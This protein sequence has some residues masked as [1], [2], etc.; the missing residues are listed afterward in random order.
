M[1][2]PW[3]R[4]RSPLTESIRARGTLAKG[5]EKQLARGCHARECPFPAGVPRADLLRRGGRCAW[6]RQSWSRPA[7]LRCLAASS[8]I[9][10][11]RVV[12]LPRA[13]SRISRSRIPHVSAARG[14]AFHRSAARSEAHRRRR[15]LC[16]GPP[17]MA[18][19]LSAQLLFAAGGEMPPPLNAFRSWAGKQQ[20]PH[21]ANDQSPEQVIH[22]LSS[23]PDEESSFLSL[24]KEELWSYRDSSL[25]RKR[26]REP[27]GLQGGTRLTPYDSPS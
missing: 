25:A 23:F 18:G 12:A 21:V 16:D 9:P 26:S 13:P 17:K 2:L 22:Y 15:A 10:Y 1:G 27:G 5:Q 6:S 19:K 3:T 4:L 20:T 11:L 7:L 8:R 24:A 14:V